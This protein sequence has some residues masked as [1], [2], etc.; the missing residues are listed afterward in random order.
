MMSKPILSFIFL[1]GASAAF[2]F[3]Q[4]KPPA[5]DVRF[6][7]KAAQGGMAEVKLGQ[8]AADK[9]SSQAVKD[10]GQRMVTDHTKAN[11]QLK[12]LASR[13]GVTLPD[14][15]DAK[16]QTIYDHLSKLSGAEF[17]RE[18][19][20]GMVKDH[21]TDV[22]EF[23]KESESAKD[24]DVREFAKQTLPTLEEHLKLAQQDESQIGTTARK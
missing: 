18:Y 9:G 11:N 15:L 2:V 23:R 17:D 13:K 7:E 19:M 10:F 20:R 6:M 1:A 4:T 5:A 14:S 16:D 12:D 3:A 8:L 24:A 21:R 22:N